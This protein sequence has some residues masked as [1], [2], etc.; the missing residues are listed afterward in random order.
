M[1]YIYSDCVILKRKKNMKNDEIEGGGGL[2]YFEFC[3]GGGVL[4]KG[5]LHNLSNFV[6]QNMT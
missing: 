4:R 6:M 1:L 3:L 5:G 2:N